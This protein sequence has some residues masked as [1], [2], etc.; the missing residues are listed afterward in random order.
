MMMMIVYLVLFS[1]LFHCERSDAFTD[2]YLRPWRWCAMCV[3]WEESRCKRCADVTYSAGGCRKAMRH[4]TQSSGKQT[5][6][7][8]RKWQIF[9]SGYI[10]IGHKNP[11]APVRIVYRTSPFMN[12]SVRI[13]Y[14]PIDRVLSANMLLCAACESC[15]LLWEEA[16]RFV[17]AWIRCWIFADAHLW[18]N[19]IK[20]LVFIRFINFPFRIYGMNMYDI[21]SLY[22][23]H[24]FL[25]HNTYN[26]IVIVENFAIFFAFVKISVL[27]MSSW[28]MSKFPRF[29]SRR[30]WISHNAGHSADDNLRLK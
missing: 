30:R 9:G 22:P 1:F 23:F 17:W 19:L 3:W 14:A 11:A 27:F 25:S 10:W 15:L 26:W 24:F 4:S 13:W 6:R 7:A 21:P 18:R 2:I 20:N 5:H 29:C 12:V 16:P 28:V 8:Q